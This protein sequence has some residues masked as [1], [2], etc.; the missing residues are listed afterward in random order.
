MV[1]KDWWRYQVCRS[2]YFSLV[3]GK[4]SVVH[5]FV[6]KLTAVT[7]RNRKWQGLEPSRQSCLGSWHRNVPTCFVPNVVILPVND[8]W[9]FDSICLVLPAQCGNLRGHLILHKELFMGNKLAHLAIL[10]KECS[11]ILLLPNLWIK[12][13]GW[14]LQQ[15]HMDVLLDLWHHQSWD[16]LLFMDLVDNFHPIFRVLWDHLFQDIKDKVLLSNASIIKDAIAVCRI[17]NWWWDPLLSAF[18]HLWVL[19]LVPNMV[20]IQGL[21]GP[22]FQP[23]NNLH[24]N[25]LNKHFTT[26]ML[27]RTLFGHLLVSNLHLHPFFLPNPALPTRI[28][29][30]QSRASRTILYLDKLLKV[31]K[32]LKVL[33]PLQPLK[34][35]QFYHINLF[36]L[37][38]Q[39]FKLLKF[40]KLLKCNKVINLSNHQQPWDKSPMSQL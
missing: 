26:M 24:L 32:F 9:W 12:H 2:E 33:K 38:L 23:S 18:S 21:L 1:Q 14:D 19:D 10:S 34:V 30:S 39:L 6:V 13:S 11:R 3:F 31:L 37:D 20:D 5:Q 16:Q 25:Y 15:G 27:L 7:S 29:T 36:T 17:S 40:L 4:V 28:R 35:H 22:P 8:I